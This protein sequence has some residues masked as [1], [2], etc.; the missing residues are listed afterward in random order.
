MIALTF[1]MMWCARH[2]EPFR[3]TWPSGAMLAM[4]NLFTASAAD[5][6]ILVAAEGHAD[7]LEP[8]LREHGPMC[9][10]LPAAV[11]EAVVSASL[12]GRKWEP[13]TP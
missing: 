7:R 13:V 1:S 9:C 2:L 4:L 10:F 5:E 6:R 3:A 12:E 8:V 11:T